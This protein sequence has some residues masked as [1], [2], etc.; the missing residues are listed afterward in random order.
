MIIIICKKF[1]IDYYQIDI[2]R[3]HIITGFFILLIA[4][5][6]LEQWHNKLSGFLATS[7]LLRRW[8]V[9]AL[10]IWWKPLLFTLLSHYIKV[11]IY[12]AEK[13]FMFDAIIRHWCSKWFPLQNYSISTFY[14]TFCL[15]FWRLRVLQSNLTKPLY[16]YHIV[17]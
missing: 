1:K 3:N 14:H 7:R 6:S 16:I 8:N 13:L 4:Y 11:F 9:F 15:T 17:K 10:I 12:R 2:N 5:T